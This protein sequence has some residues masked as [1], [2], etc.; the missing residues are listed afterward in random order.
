MSRPVALFQHHYKLGRETENFI[1]TSRSIKGASRRYSRI[2]ATLVP[3]FP[4]LVEPVR[5]WIAV[6]VPQL[7]GFNGQ[8][9][10]V[11]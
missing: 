9:A 10:C 8:V 4:R 1:K 6:S 7:P 2:Q 3:D 5:D 11:Y